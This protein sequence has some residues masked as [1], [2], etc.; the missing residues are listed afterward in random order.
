MLKAGLFT[1]AKEPPS[2]NKK[3]PF[4]IAANPKRVLGILVGNVVHELKATLYTSTVTGN[5]TPSLEPP[6]L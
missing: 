5:V 1:F 4:A 2:A 3:L 6:R